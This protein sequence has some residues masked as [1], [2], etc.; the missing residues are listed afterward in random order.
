MSLVDVVDCFVFYDDVN[1]IK[2]GWINRNYVIA[3]GKPH[4]FSLPFEK[5]CILA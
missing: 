1:F 2:K 5:N 3:D 4:R